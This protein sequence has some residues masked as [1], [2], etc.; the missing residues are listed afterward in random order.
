[1]IPELD[2]YLDRLEL[3]EYHSRSHQEE[4]EN[5]LLH[6]YFRRRGAARIRR[7]AALLGLLILSL[8]GPSAFLAR[9][10]NAEIQKSLSLSSFR[11]LIYLNRLT[12]ATGELA[13]RTVADYL[14]LDIDQ[15]TVVVTRAGKPW[16]LTLDGQG[17]P[18]Q[19]PLHVVREVEFLRQKGRGR[20]W[21]GSRRDD[22][23]TANVYRY[24]LTDGQQVWASEAELS[25]IDRLHP[26]KAAQVLGLRTQRIID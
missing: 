1:M 15:D 19:G 9:K 5:Q 22:G 12:I 16:V 2:R 20:T 26:H 14:V 6:Y 18:L 8:A 10:Y 17:F 11:L 3:P 24:S 13:L 23:T 7:R 25:R 4:L 21:L